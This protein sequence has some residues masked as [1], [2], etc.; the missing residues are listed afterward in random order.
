MKA[1]LHTQAQNADLVNVIGVE[2]NPT[3]KSF[4]AGCFA[5]KNRRGQ[6]PKL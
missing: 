1:P 4:E 5:K 2:Q 6:R 3:I